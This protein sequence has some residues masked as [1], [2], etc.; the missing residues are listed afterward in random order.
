MVQEERFAVTP[1]LSK[2]VDLNA[3]IEE[4]QGSSEEIKDLYEEAVEFISYFSWLEG[5]KRAY[6]GLIHPGIV[7][8]FLV[9]IDKLRDDV[10]DWLW[11][12]VGDL[13]P[14]YLTCEN[15]KNP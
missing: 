1:D 9:N 12:I 8:V 2:V 5:I 13:P 14:A 6:A 11:I 4:N 3:Y 7:G 10:D 15:C